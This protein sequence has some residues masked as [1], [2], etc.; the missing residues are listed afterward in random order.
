VAEAG[1]PDWDPER[2]NRVKAPRQR[3]APRPAIP[4]GD[5]EA[6]ARTIREVYAGEQLAELIRLLSED[7]ARTS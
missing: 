7:A 4:A 1:P 5:P 3:S 2:V 6:A